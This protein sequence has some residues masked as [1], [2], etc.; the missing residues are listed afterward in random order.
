MERTE[1][2][3]GAPRGRRLL[4]RILLYA[5]LLIVAAVA[6]LPF[7]YVISTAFKESRAL[8][9]Y[10]PRFLPIPP[11]FGNI[12]RLIFEYPFARWFLNTLFVVTAVTGLK[13]LIDSL[14][15]YA[16]AKLDF[17]GK[18][19]IFVALLATLMVPFAAI[20]MPLLAMVQGAGLVDTYWALI[21]PPLANPI[22]I[23]LM[24]QFMESLPR[25]LDNSARMDGCS[26]FAVYRHVVMPLVKPA[27]TILA[28]LHLLTQWN[29]FLWPLIVTRSPEMQVLTVGIAGL[30]GLL[31][32]DWGLI[33]TGALL[34]LAPLVV[35]S[36]LF[37]RY[38]VAAS[39]SGALKE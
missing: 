32:V 24:R 27:L 18:E 16:F 8:F 4:E 1:R 29:S 36:V 23:F 34:A 21:L 15:G 25:D 11:Y 26:E 22:G 33:A 17:P 38:F 7:I 3:Q 13:L 10:P 6:L 14:A 31:R 39:L 20:M 12:E 35:L 30:K 19:K 9:T 37:Q 28:V 5:A 2:R